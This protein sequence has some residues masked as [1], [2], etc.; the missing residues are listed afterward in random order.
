MSGSG[1]VLAVDGG[2]SSTIALVFE[3]T[4]LLV[5]AARGACADIYGA[6]TPSEA[7]AEVTATARA[8]LT[9]AGVTADGLEVAAFGLAGADWP[10]DFRLLEAEL[11]AA[12][13]TSRPPLVINDAVGALWTGTRDGRGVAAVCG[14]YACIAASGPA[15]TWHSSFWSEPA[16]AVHLAE[17]ALRAACRA[18]L[19]T[20]P[21]TALRERMLL[22]GGFASTEDLLHHYTRR[23]RPPRWEIARFAPLILDVAEDGDRVAIQL[24]RDQAEAVVR[25]VRAGAKQAGLSGSYPLV[26]AGGMFS[27]D[28]SRLVDALSEALPQAHPVVPRVQPA[29]G[30]ALMAADVVG[31]PLPAEVALATVIA[32]ADLVSW[33][34]VQAT[35]A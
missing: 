32:E 33:R 27:H 14:T 3:P 24:I 34:D 17:A 35:L 2:N 8:A 22:A 20:G 19:G 16:G 21:A 7:I 25:S 12:F 23:P 11:G 6:Q 9:G 18:E 28:S 30:V 15:R 26:L 10:E 5:G 29:V 13:Q 31:L 4:G 1:H